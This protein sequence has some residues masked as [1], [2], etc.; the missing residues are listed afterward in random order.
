RA[1]IAWSHGD[2]RSAARLFT[3]ARVRALERR[4]PFDA[5]LVALELALVHLVRGRTAQVRKLAFEAL[6]IFA[7][8][9]VERETRA[10]LELLEAAA[11]RDALTRELVE[12]AISALEG[13]R[14]A[15]PAPGREPS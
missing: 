6:G 11:R 3:E 2:L 4:V 8:Q 5:G 15:H 13:A 10:A 14:H 1:R 7:E 12:R 9:D